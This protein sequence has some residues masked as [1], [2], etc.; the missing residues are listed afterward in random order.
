MGGRVEEVGRHRCWEGRSREEAGR[1]APVGRRGWGSWG[2]G[3]TRRALG[4]GVVGAGWERREA[5]RRVRR[6]S[7]RGRGG[8]GRGAEMGEGRGGSAGSGPGGRG[9]KRGGGLPRWGA[10]SVKWASGA[11]VARRHGQVGGA[12]GTK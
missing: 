9:G 5:G 7:G 12:A 2:A 8:E 6:W 1:P 3:T 11:D 10:P 4:G